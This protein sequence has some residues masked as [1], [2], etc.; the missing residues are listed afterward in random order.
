MTPQCVAP[1]S[2]RCHPQRGRLFPPRPPKTTECVANAPRAPPLGVSGG[3]GPVTGQYS[4]AEASP[5]K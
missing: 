4:D 3:W 5:W 2:G 1:R